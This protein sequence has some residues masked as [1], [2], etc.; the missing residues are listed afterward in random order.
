MELASFEIIFLSLVLHFIKGTTGYD[1]PGDF[2]FSSCPRPFIDSQDDTVCCRSDDGIYT[3]CNGAVLALWA[4]IVI[5]MVLLVIVVIFSVILC[6]ICPCCWIAARRN[7]QR[8]PNLLQPNQVVVNHQPPSYGYQTF[9]GTDPHAYNNKGTV[10]YSWI[11]TFNSIYILIGSKL[12][13]SLH[14][15]VNVFYGM[16]CFLNDWPNQ[17]TIFRCKITPRYQAVS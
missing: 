10:T 11:C 6:C 7:Q 3:C 9:S 8:P 1:C 13:T 15:K 2:P 12:S 5:C 4:I 14:L 17:C 16:M